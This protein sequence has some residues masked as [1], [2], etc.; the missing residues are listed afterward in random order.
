[1]SNKLHITQQHF[2][3]QKKTSSFDGTL[4]TFGIETTKTTQNR[5]LK[6][7]ATATLLQTTYVTKLGRTT[8]LL[9][10]QL[11]FDRKSHCHL[12]TS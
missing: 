9:Q 1:M 2:T 7:S 10:L 8:P 5:I 4:T 11:I 6:I 12:R 3:K